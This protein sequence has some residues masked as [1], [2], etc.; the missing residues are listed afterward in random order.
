MRTHWARQ[1]RPATLNCTLKAPSDSNFSLEWRKDGQLIHSAYGDEPGHSSPG[2]QGRIG[3]SDALGLTVHSVQR[4]D[5]AVYSCSIVR[6]YSTAPAAPVVGPPVRL[7][8]N[9]PPIISE[10]SHGEIIFAEE[11]N[12]AEI[13]CV[14]SAVPPPEV[15]WIKNG[16]I[17]SASNILSIPNVTVGH[18]GSYSCLS[19]NSEG[20][21]EAVIE[22]RFPKRVHFD[23]PPQNKSVVAGSSSFWNCHATGYPDR[24]N[25]EW[26]FEGAPVKSTAVGKRVHT[27]NGE[28]AIR[29]VKKEDRGWYTC[30]ASN[31]FGES[32]TAAYLDVQYLPETLSNNP[33]V[34]TLGVGSN[35]TLKCAA[36]ANPKVTMVNWS[37]N[38][39]FVAT[40]DKDFL[41]LHNVSMDDA[42]LYICEVFNSLGRGTPFEMHVIVAQPPAFIVKPPPEIRVKV[43]AKLD[44]RCAGFADPSPIQYWIRNQERTASEGF[45]ID[46][47]TYEDEGI[48]ECIVSNAVSTIK[49]ETRVHVEDTRPQPPAI[50]EVE[51]DGD[52][53]LRI[54]W[55]GGFDGGHPQRF[56]AYA[57]EL[58]EEEERSTAMERRAETDNTEVTVE[59]LSPFGKYRITVEAVNRLGSANS[60]SVDRHV[61]T[62]LASPED[63]RLDRDRLVWQPVEGAH[64]YR[65]EMR[66]GGGQYAQVAE[67][68]HPHY[69]IST[70]A[71]LSEEVDLRIIGLRPPF[72]P[73]TPS[74]PVTIA[75]R[76]TSQDGNL[77]FRLCGGFFFFIFLALIF[78]FAR[79]NSSK[80][81][82][83]EKNATNSPPF[84]SS[85][86]AVNTPQIVRQLYNNSNPLP[87]T[88]IGHYRRQ[89]RFVH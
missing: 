18:Q 3:R 76:G 20:R 38:G 35:A 84:H 63:P 14:S 17:V 55:Q 72:A 62:K 15:S 80:L 71:R 59:N 46:N 43:G 4:E 53:G 66:N 1:G 79:R 9:V 85:G 41:E 87:L 29:D 22:L 28:L 6:F 77:L 36:D 27:G 19:A 25:Y 45:S 52:R 42:G 12:P 60:T 50:K 56:I 31:I 47:V 2:L 7:V 11:S 37:R 74:R 48:Y 69:T 70:A 39:H 33:E 51:C 89:K 68:L 26:K 24:I 64:S 49:S 78:L 13:K 73:S 86:C 61:C 81:R 32:M 16:K 75:M 40:K 88:N 82:R 65:V 30:H 57:E 23:Y 54:N 10:P 58:G 21:V 44:L 8:V 83:K 5:E 67:V 34:Y